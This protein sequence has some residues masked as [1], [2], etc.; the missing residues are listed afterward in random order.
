MNLPHIGQDSLILILMQME[1]KTRTKFLQTTPIPGLKPK[2][3]DFVSKLYPIDSKEK[4]LKTLYQ[5]SELV[6]HG[7]VPPKEILQLNWNETKNYLFL[8]MQEIKAI[9]DFLKLYFDCG[10]IYTPSLNNMIQTM[11]RKEFK[12]YRTI[13][14][15]VYK[16]DKDPGETFETLF[17]DTWTIAKHRTEIIDEWIVYQNISPQDIAEYI[18]FDYQNFKM[19]TDIILIYFTK[20]LN[21]ASKNYVPFIEEVLKYS[22]DEYKKD[23]ELNLHLSN[24]FVRLIQEALE[25]E[26]WRKL[27]QRLDKYSYLMIDI[28]CAQVKHI[29]C[30]DV[31]NKQE[32]LDW[33]NERIN[34]IVLE[35]PKDII[36]AYLIKNRPHLL[37][38]LK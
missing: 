23:S 3:R 14:E 21:E 26:N 32:K 15:Q 30:C 7:G 12:L 13:Y 27:V 28:F 35:R 24:F 18:W 34:Q 8:R 37:N 29:E 6:R 9:T 36:T 11:D 17:I 5:L 22:F 10:F 25:K 19:D 1:P 2:L 33:L 31:E 16:M 20:S 38:L 4:S